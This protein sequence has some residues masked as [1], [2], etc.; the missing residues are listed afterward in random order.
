MDFNRIKNNK[1]FNTI[2]GILVFFLVV[3]II[4]KIYKSLADKAKKRPYLVK[5]PKDATKPIV[6]E[7]SKLL[8]STVGRE[9]SF[10]F[11]LYVKDWGHNF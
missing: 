3:F 7:G 1:H 10:S 9:F 8:R 2:M 5:G 11:W 6:L 4:Y